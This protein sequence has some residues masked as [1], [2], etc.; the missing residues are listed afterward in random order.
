MG[1]FDP[2]YEKNGTRDLELYDCYCTAYWLASLVRLVH[3]HS[4]IEQDKENFPQIYFG[5]SMQ[6]CGKTLFVCFFFCF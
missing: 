2:F 3:G 6:L 5:V 1:V 4:D